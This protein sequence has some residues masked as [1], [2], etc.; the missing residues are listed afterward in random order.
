MN[1][2]ITTMAGST[3]R[4]LT[5]KRRPTS[6][7][8]GIGEPT[9]MPNVANFERATEWVAAHGC[10]YSPQIGDLAFRATV[11]AHYR[12]PGLDRAENVCV[13][14]GSQ[15]AVYL[16]L[17]TLLD[18]HEDELLIVE[19]AFTVYA[20]IAQVEGIPHRRLEFAP[21]DPAPFDPERILAA[22]G[23]RTRMILVCSPGNPTGRAF[24][25]A[26]ARALAE[27]LLARPGPPL[28]VLHDEIYR[29]LRYVDDVASFAE[30]YPYTVA[31]NS[32][33]K[34]NALTGLRIGWLIAPAETMPH[35]AK[36]HGWT[37]SSPSTFAQRVAHEVF[38]A[39]ELGAHRGWY[40]AQ[41]EGVL[42]EARALG[43]THVVPEGAFYLC[44]RFGAPDESGLAF[45]EALLD[46]RDV[47]AIPAEIFG[48]TMR[49]W[50][51]TSFVAPL[52]EVR[53]G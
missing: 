7:N 44:V 8:L 24:D 20:K 13:T 29:E 43:L 34:S 14:T 11:A 21:T 15:E 31:V 10:R 52:D 25:S 3:I 17:R 53:E 45:A 48:A 33:S 9:L 46:E 32:L 35:L 38:A 16:A 41:R 30:F 47:V 39:D 22:L 26:T 23:P 36:L 5:A 42:A 1:P 6:L 49:G 18:P 19:P 28:Y 4:A 40:A 50:L 51:R 27:G 2:T 12:F 37:T